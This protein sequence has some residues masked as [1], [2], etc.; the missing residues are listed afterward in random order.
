MV[1]VWLLALYLRSPCQAAF[2]QE[3]PDATQNYVVKSNTFVVRV[4]HLTSSQFSR[5]PTQPFAAKL[6]KS[7]WQEPDIPLKRVVSFVRQ[8]AH[9]FRNGLNCLDL[10]T[11]ILEEFVSGD[12]GQACLRRLRKQ[13]RSLAEQLRS[14]SSRFQD[15]QPVTGSISARE[16]LLIWREK[17]SAL[18]DPP[19]VSWQ[20]KF[21][22]EKVSVDVEM[23][24]AVFRELLVNAGAFSKGASLTV[25][26]HFADGNAIFELREPK[27]EKLDPSSWGHA[28][29]TTRSDGYG[30][31]LWGA[32]RLIH[33]NGAKIMQ[34]YTPEDE[35]LTTQISIPAS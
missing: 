10:E 11:A 19:E 34:R 4:R 2:T 9:D 24:A 12:E 16:L 27:K 26:A 17:H 29:S 7:M 5:Q 1:V 25:S 3:P 30:L 31:G 13:L 6:K 22:D 14:L 20:D 23:I 35:M 32:R 8:H 21:G 33:A 18:E 15:P 28:L